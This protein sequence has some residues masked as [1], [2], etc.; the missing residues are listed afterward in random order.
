MESGVRGHDA[1]KVVVV[2]GQD[3]VRD[4]GERRRWYR[5]GPFQFVAAVLPE[6]VVGVD[7]RAFFL[8]R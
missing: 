3:V 6:A 4:L 5:A 7:V 8:V 1:A 2:D